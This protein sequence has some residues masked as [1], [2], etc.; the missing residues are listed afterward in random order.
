M[1]RDRFAAIVEATPALPDRGPVEAIEA[2]AG[3]VL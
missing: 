3:R 2:L 1:T